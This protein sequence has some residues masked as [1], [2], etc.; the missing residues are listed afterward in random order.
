MDIGEFATGLSVM[1]AMQHLKDFKFH[2]IP[3]KIEMVFLKKSRGRIAAVCTTKLDGIVEE[4]ERM[5]TAM[6]LDTKG[7]EVARFNVTWSFKM[8]KS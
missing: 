3:V 1:S 4:C 2:G 7:A 6:I 5:F 8:R